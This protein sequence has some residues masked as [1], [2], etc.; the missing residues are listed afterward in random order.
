VAVSIAI[1]KPDH[2]GDLVLSVPA[3]RAVRAHCEEVALFVASNSRALAGYLFPDIP[4]VRSVDL[5]HLS[6][7]GEEGMPLDVLASELNRFDHVLCLRDDPVMRDILSRLLVP[8]TIA[9]GSHLVHE[10]ST[11]KQ[12]VERI[13]GRYSRT[14]LFTGV[15]HAWP[16]APRHLALCIAAGFPTN[17]WPNT[18]WA[19]L[20]LRLGRRDMQVTLIGGPGER[21]DLLMLSRLLRRIRHDILI[22]SDDF[23]GFLEALEPVD[24]IV[25]TDGGTA[26][27]CSLRKPVCS[28]FGS[29]PWRRYAPFG[30]SNVLITRDELCSPCVQFS[31]R[32]LNG[33]LTR[34]CMAR[35]DPGTVMQVILSNGLDFSTVTGVRVERGTS[36]GYGCNLSSTLSK[37]GQSHRL[38]KLWKIVSSRKISW[39]RSMVRLSRPKSPNV[40][41]RPL[42]SDQ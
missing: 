16:V 27:I 7:R 26:H 36:H 1:L 23:A 24:L 5:R 2:L 14:R 35:I 41:Q 10:T 39:A 12:A 28:I 18:Y 13:C 21:D 42:M 15:P 34:E 37:N 31:T 40:R 20:A 22:G 33:C 4:D 11:Q 38:A 29:S 17:R 30:R 3:V 25:A 8:C 19:D 32:E 6:R 9:S